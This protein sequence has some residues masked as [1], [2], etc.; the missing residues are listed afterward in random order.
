METEELRKEL[1][2]L[3]NERIDALAK[4]TET[5]PEKGW[6]KSKSGSL[7]NRTGESFGFGIGASGRWYDDGFGWSF[8]HTN[9]WRPATD[10]EVES[11]LDKEC[12]RKYKNGDKYACFEND[13]EKSTDI[14]RMDFSHAPV[15]SRENDAFGYSGLGW[16][17]CK[18]KFAEIIKDEINIVGERVRYEGFA[19]RVADEHYTKEYLESCIDLFRAAKV[20]GIQITK[21]NGD[22]VIVTRE[23]IQNVLNNWK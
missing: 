16:V 13:G 17:Y 9:E 8:H 20:T 21:R 14:L 18:G 19:I 12:K 5:L 4:K 11:A 22:K 1:I 6:M 7:I 15:Y 3:I 10:S 23:E 2:G